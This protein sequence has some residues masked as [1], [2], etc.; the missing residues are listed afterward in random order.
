[1][2]ALVQTHRPQED[3]PGHWH[4]VDSPGVWTFHVLDRMWQRLGLQSYILAVLGVP[5]E[6]LG[7]QPGVALGGEE[8]DEQLDLTEL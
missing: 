1:M 4:W 5:M 3:V 8:Q 2:A 6:E 7:N